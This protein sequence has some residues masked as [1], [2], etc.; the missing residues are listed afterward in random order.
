M[1]QLIVFTILVV[2]HNLKLLSLVISG[3]YHKLNKHFILLLA[4]TSVDIILISL[5]VRATFVANISAHK[6]R[7]SRVFVKVRPL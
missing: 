6:Q 5:A 1:N 7:L 3:L 2:F 4:T